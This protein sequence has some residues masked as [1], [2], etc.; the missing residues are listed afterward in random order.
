VF[1]LK[2][3]PAGARPFSS[4]LGFGQ[5]EIL[6]LAKSPRADVKTQLPPEG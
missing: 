2:P 3:L 5:L 4:P 6:T 1:G